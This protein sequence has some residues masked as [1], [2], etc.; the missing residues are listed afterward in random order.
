[1]KFATGVHEAASSFCM[2]VCVYL[3]E[4][5][6][7]ICCMLLATS[8]PPE[9]L[10]LLLFLLQF[11]FLLLFMPHSPAYFHIVIIRA[12][13]PCLHRRF[14]GT[15]THT[16]ICR[17][18]LYSPFLTRTSSATLLRPFTAV[19]FVFAFAAMSAFTKWAIKV[20]GSWFHSTLLK[21]LLLLLQLEYSTERPS[22]C[23]CLLLLEIFY[24]YYFCTT[25]L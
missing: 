24:C 4:Y 21:H 17:Y 8:P 18:L 15:H 23:V 22:G 16:Y 6:Y 10:L 12:T 14:A 19:A 7:C 2:C 5:S 13:L 20:T 11:L 9:L 25:A 1:M 3:R